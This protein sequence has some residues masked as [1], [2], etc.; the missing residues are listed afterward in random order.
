MPRGSE[1]S[2]DKTWGWSDGELWRLRGALVLSQDRWSRGGPLRTVFVTVRGPPTALLWLRVGWQFC[3]HLRL[4]QPV[5]INKTILIIEKNGSCNGGL[6]SI[7][8]SWS[9]FA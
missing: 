1:E 6:A 3:V 4:P 2:A 8:N 9:E 5:M 7:G